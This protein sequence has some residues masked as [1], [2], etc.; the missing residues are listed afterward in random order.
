MRGGLNRGAGSPLRRSRG[1]VRALIPAL[2]LLQLAPL[3]GTLV[4]VLLFELSGCVLDGGVRSCS[5]EDLV[6]L[7][8]AG[9]ALGFSVLLLPVTLGVGV[10][11]GLTLWVSGRLRSRPA[12]GPE[13]R[14]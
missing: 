7:G 9:Y 5:E 13:R 11:L 2:V 3:F 10:G 6:L 12:P 8:R 14:R 4:G 1:G